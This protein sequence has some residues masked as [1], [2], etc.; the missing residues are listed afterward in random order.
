MRNSDQGAE[1]V[2]ASSLQAF[3]LSSPQAFKPSRLTSSSLGRSTA[4]IAKLRAELRDMEEEVQRLRDREA[5]AHADYRDKL[6]VAHLHD[7]GCFSYFHPGEG[8]P[9][10]NFM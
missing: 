3:K 7:V 8:S 2:K 10:V 9:L 1:E 5:K 6:L 4:E